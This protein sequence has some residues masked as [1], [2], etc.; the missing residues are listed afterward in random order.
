MSPY[1]FCP[2][3]L[4]PVYA[5]LHAKRLHAGFLNREI[6]LDYLDR[7][8][9]I[10]SPQKKEEIRGISD[11][12]LEVTPASTAGSEMKGTINKVIQVASRS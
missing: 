11:S 12:K 9:I 3:L 2:L 7:F 8:N 1:A 4:T 6:I 5:V 10:A